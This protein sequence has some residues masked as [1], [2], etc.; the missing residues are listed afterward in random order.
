MIVAADKIGAMDMYCITQI[1]PERHERWCWHVPARYRLRRVW[2][3]NTR[4]V[5]MMAKVVW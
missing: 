2:R 4:K 5:V 1:V 3:G